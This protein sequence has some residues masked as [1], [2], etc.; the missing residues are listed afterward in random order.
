[1][2]KRGRARVVLGSGALAASLACGAGLAGAQEVARGAAET[3][4]QEERAGDAA[5]RR[6][7]AGDCAAALDAYDVALRTSIDPALRRDRGLCHEQL[8]HPY[9]AID[10]YRAYLTARPNAP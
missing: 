3:K 7:K 10:D 9:P 8:G 6:A 2:M 4:T 5:H 1:M